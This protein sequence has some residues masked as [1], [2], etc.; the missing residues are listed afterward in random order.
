MGTETHVKPVRVFIV[1]D[2]QVVAMDIRNRLQAMGYQALGVAATAVEALALI[3]RLRPDLVLMDIVLHGKPDGIALADQVLKRFAVPVVFLT[4]HAD[5]ATLDQAKRAEPFGYILKPFTD[6]KLQTTI[7]TALYHH[8]MDCRLK[9]S[10]QRYREMVEIISD[11]VWEIDQHSVFTA[12]S[13]RVYDILGYR[14]EEIIGKTPFDLMPPGEAGR[15]KAQ[16]EDLM[17]RRE[18]FRHLENVNLHKN[19]RRVVLETTGIPLFDPSGMFCGYHGVDRDI[20]DRRQIEE[21]RNRLI[22]ELQL[23]NQELGQFVYI[24]SHDLQEPLRM[25]TSYVQLLK[26][27]YHGRLDSDADEFIH[28][29]VEGTARMQILIR[30]LLHYSRVGTQVLKKEPID[31]GKLME[32]VLSIV[33]LG[34]D[35]SGAVVAWENLP[36]IQG[37]PIQI[38]QLFQNLVS[39]AIKF[40]S[41]RHPKVHIS[42][43]RQQ[44]H[45][46]FAIRDNGI[47][48]DAQYYERIFLIFQRLHPR[49]VY[50]GSGIGLAICK[51]VVERHDGRIWVESEPGKGATFYFTLPVDPVDKENHV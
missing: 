12:A 32:H 38:T 25:V 37:D 49:G 14:P 35:Q 17:S 4:A 42:A 28:F 41:G 2:E 9:A 36:F 13:P 22:E 24:A 31:C 29:T 44:D 7:E 10:E 45:W 18:S 46:V 30:N 19:G 3:D 43:R 8:D 26:K 50:P 27:R 16:F 15:V 34:I 47:G 40:H 51:K 39:N 33:K 1:E 21:Q 23:S 5:R 11:W 6:L 48:I 20:T